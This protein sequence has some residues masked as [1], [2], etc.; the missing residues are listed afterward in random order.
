MVVV[1]LSTQNR[2]NERV[3]SV[4]LVCVRII[5]RAIIDFAVGGW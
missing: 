5:A 4:H 2:Q 3:Y 1:I